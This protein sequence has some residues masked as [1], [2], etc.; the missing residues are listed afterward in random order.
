MCKIIQIAAVA[1][2]VMA[3]PAL[4]ADS[5]HVALQIKP[6]LWEFTDIPKV[7]GDTIVADTMLAHVQPAQRAQFVTQMRQEMTQ[8]HKAREC[9]TQAKFEQ[10]V[11]LNFPGCTRTVATNTAAAFDVR[12][13][14]RGEAHG[15]KEDTRQRISVSGPAT[16]ATSTHAVTTRGGKTMTIDATNTG[17][18]IGTECK[19]GDV[20][21]QLP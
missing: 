12:S 9:F 8:P 2:A 21:Q 10:R 11:S 19:L 20:I 17:R 4:G 1:F 15:T 16:V 5:L 13:V 7:T 6:G 3:A 18:W 14:C